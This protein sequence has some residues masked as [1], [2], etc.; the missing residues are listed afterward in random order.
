MIAG[1][2]LST[3]IPARLCRLGGG[4]KK[5]R[6]SATIV[7]F[8]IVYFAASKL[9][10][11]AAYVHP[12]AS[13]VWPCTGIALAALLVLGYDVWPGIFLGAFLVNITTAGSR[14]CLGLLGNC[15]R[16][17]LGG[18]RWGLSGQSFC[19]RTKCNGPHAGRRWI[20]APRWP[21]R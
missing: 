16:Q 21:D 15:R 5:P 12:S 13:A 3:V 8:S 14:L 11:S 1:L 19:R 18:T 4:L 9:V 7:V 10:L 17:Y 2:W 6:T 20:H